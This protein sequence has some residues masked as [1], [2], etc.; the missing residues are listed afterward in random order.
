MT[1]NSVPASRRR[2]S[3]TAAALLLAAGAIGAGALGPVAPANAAGSWVALA[4]A[5]NNAALGWANN[6]ASAQSAR[7]DA[8]AMCQHNGG[9]DCVVPVYGENDCAAIAYYPWPKDPPNS[10]PMLADTGLQTTLG[11]AEYQAT[12]QDTGFQLLVSRC[13]TGTAGVPAQGSSG[14]AGGPPVYTG[15]PKRQLQ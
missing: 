13:S 2:R 1:A 8:L 5:P 4:W 9:T 14:P 7:T 11:A 12:H 10:A 15:G 3:V 6:E